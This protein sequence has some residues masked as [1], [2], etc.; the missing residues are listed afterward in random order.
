MTTEIQIPDR[1]SKILIAYTYF[2]TKQQSIPDYNC[3][4]RKQKL[5]KPIQYMIYPSMGPTIAIHIKHRDEQ[6]RD[7]WNSLPVPVYG[8]TRHRRA[9]RHI[10][11]PPHSFK[12]KG[13][14]KNWDFSKGKLHLIVSTKFEISRDSRE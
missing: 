3:W 9:P 5:Q 8:G 4:P 11:T 7:I 2:K 1:A 6:R 10:H 12:E 14:K 13:K